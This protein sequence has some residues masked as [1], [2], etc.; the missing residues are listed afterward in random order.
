[1]ACINFDIKKLVKLVLFLL[2]L[3]PLSCLSFIFLRSYKLLGIFFESQAI[4]HGISSSFLDKVREVAKQFF[5]LPVEEKQKYSR[6]VDGSEGY[7]NDRILSE[8]QVLDWLYRLSLR[9]RPVDQRKLQLWPENPNE[10][11]YFYPS[12]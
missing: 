5:A 11:R 2:N 8:N 10:F 4:G 1:M 9:L 6:E 7:G 12:F 3:N